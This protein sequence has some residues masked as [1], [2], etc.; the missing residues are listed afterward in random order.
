MN[1]VK[2]VIGAVLLVASI[3]GLAGCYAYYDDDYYHEHYR[4]RAYYRDNPRA[5]SYS[6]SYRDPYRDPYYYDRWGDRR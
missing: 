6:Y 3:S 2:K 1:T 5:Y 4:G